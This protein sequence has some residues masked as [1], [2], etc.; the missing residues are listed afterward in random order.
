VSFRFDCLFIPPLGNFHHE[1]LIIYGRSIEHDQELL[2]HRGLLREAEEAT[3]AM[4]RE[5]EDF[6]AAKAQE[7]ENLKEELHEHEE[8]LQEHEIELANQDNEIDNLQA[9]IH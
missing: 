1:L 3:I 6:Q 8:E 7:I 9:Q 5:L 4:A 2:R